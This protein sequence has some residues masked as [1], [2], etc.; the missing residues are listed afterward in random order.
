MPSD[1]QT[2]DE[3]I[4]YLYLNQ[5]VYFINHLITK[6]WNRWKIKKIVDKIDKSQ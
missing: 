3:R 4:V 1:D 5:M 6:P 2:K